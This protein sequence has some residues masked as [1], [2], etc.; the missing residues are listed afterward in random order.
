MSEA[1]IEIR[2]GGV[3]ES[4]HRVC[5]AVV[6]G[7]GR[8]RASAGDARHPAFA[9]SAV[10]PIQAVPVVEDGAAQQFQMSDRELALCCASHSGEARH[11]E[12]VAAMLRR[13][14]LGEEALACGPQE[15][16]HSPSAQ[17]LRAAGRSAGRLHN[18]CSGK[19]AG[20]LALARVRGWPTTGYHREDHPVQQRMLHEMARWTGVRV[21]DIPTAVDGCGVITFGLTVEALAG[22]FAR[23]AAGTRHGDDVVARIV[24]A[25]VK[26][27]DFVAGAGRLCTRLMSVAGGRIFAKVGAEGV[28]CAGIPGAELGVALKVEDGAMRA[29]EPAL[30]ATLRVLDVLSADEIAQLADFAEPDVLN[31]RGERVGEVRAIVSLVPC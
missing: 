19:H 6:D 4:V 1:R 31:T 2:R 3:V 11:V 20:M 13:L 25:M 17:A 22:A 18:N 12:T 5:I 27:P 8:L 14:G 10:K 15:P 28:Y 23:M 7:S 26:W 16:R 24:G 30:L 9:R 29:A 21:E